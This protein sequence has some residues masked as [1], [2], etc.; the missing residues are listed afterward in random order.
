MGEHDLKRFLSKDFMEIIENFIRIAEDK[1][2]VNIDEDYRSFFANFITEA[3]AGIL[4]ELICK[5]KEI[6]RDKI[7]YFVQVTT[8]NTIIASLK[9][10]N[11]KA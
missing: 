7:N 6:S 5:N 3:I 9:V 8:T 2:D 4:I 10:Y 11:N 1:L